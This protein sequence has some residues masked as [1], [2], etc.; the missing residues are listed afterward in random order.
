MENS[1]EKKWGEVGVINGRDMG[2]GSKRWREWEME[3]MRRNPG[4]KW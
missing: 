3:E 4:Y 1:G 2:D